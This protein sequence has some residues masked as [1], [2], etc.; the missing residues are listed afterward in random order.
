MEWN[1]PVGEARACGGDAL[2]RVEA[3]HQVG[4][5]RESLI[6]GEEPEM[7]VRLRQH[8]WKIQRLDAE[9]TLHD[10]AMFHCW[11]WFRRAKRCGH[12]YAEGAWLHGA[13]PERH[14]I[15]ESQRIW[16]WGLIWPALVLIATWYAGPWALAAFLVYPIQVARIARHR[17]RQFGD[18]WLHCVQYALA[19]TLAKWPELLG[20]IEF[21]RNRVRGRQG[22]LIEYKGA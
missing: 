18:Q 10:A 12:A 8:G 22:K 15:R 1:T 19:C 16:F 7:C 3:L 4:G 5:Y 2:M 17:Q 14:Y 9:M 20:Q 11:Q 13:P 6:A 21:W